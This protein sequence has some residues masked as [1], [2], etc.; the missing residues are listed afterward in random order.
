MIQYIRHTFEVLV[1]NLK[2]Y[3]F[4]VSVDFTAY[5]M[6]VLHNFYHSIYLTALVTSY[7]QITVTHVLPI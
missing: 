3:H 1:L 6:Q 2:I 4:C 5:K 7:F